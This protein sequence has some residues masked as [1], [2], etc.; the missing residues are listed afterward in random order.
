MRPGS[1]TSPHLAI[2]SERKQA[3]A[4]PFPLLLTT[5]EP[6]PSG[7]CHVP[8]SAPRSRRQIRGR[9]ARRQTGALWL[10]SLKKEGKTTHRRGDKSEWRAAD[11]SRL[12]IKQVLIKRA[13]C[14]V[15]NH[16]TKEVILS[17]SGRLALSGRQL[18]Q[19]NALSVITHQSKQRFA[20]WLFKERQIC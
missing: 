12:H 5:M 9:C 2:P 7:P 11:G 4:T 6:V 20:P 1:G 17:L 3:K 19:K 10:L 8:A 14:R 16:V 13:A 15:N 18:D